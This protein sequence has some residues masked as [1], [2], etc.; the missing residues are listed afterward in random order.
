MSTCRAAATVLHFDPRGRVFACCANETF[1]LGQIPGQT[2]EAIWSGEPA[3]RLRATLARDD[4]S[5][6]CGE[7]LVHQELGRPDLAWARTYDHLDPVGRPL[8]LELELTNTCNLQCVQCNGELSSAIRSQREGRPPLPKVYDDAF[9][10]QLRSLLPKVEEI[11]FLGGEPFLG[12]ETLRVFGDLISLGLRPRCHVTT[13]GTIW[14]DRVAAI[15]DQVPVDISISLDAVSPEV[16]AG[17]RVGADLGEVMANIDRFRAAA[18]RNGTSVSLNCCLMRPN[19]DDFVPLLRFADDRGL[20]VFVNR[21]NQPA[22]VSLFSLEASALS[23]AADR[24]ASAPGAEALGRNRPVLDSQVAELRALV[25]TLGPPAAEGA[26]PWEEARVL[27]QEF[28][29]G[30]RVIGLVLDDAEIVREVSTDPVVCG[31]P[32]GWVPGM[33]IHELQHALIEHFGPAGAARSTIPSSGVQQHELSFGTSD[34]SGVTIRLLRAP[35]PAGGS[36][37]F[38]AGR[39]LGAVTVSRD[40]E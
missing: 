9:F 1:V 39:P 36:A 13:N 7:C 27:A 6:G 38:V 31:A 40:A 32:V 14:N 30:G 25:A 34:Q 11:S 21:V 3:E 2:I 28:A 23:A 15:L 22:A 8:R 35:M 37:C 4:L 24:L 29:A 10:E 12:R 33:V 5:L 20:D 18:A 16:H 19:L 17:I 26:R